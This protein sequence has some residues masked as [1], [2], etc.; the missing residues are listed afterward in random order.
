MLDG[1]KKKLIAQSRRGLKRIGAQEIAH[2]LKQG[3]VK[4]QG[5]IP[6][7]ENPGCVPAA[8]YC[9][10]M[11]PDIGH[12]NFRRMYGKMDHIRNV[13]FCYFRLQYR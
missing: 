9:Q 2:C 8:Q 12:F 3:E 7:N 5:T 13:N 6:S 4:S 10:L 1:A 11:E